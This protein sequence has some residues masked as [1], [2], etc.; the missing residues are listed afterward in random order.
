M[1]QGQARPITRRKLQ[2]LGSRI[3]RTARFD[4]DTFREL[5]EDRSATG[6]AIA[7]LLIVGLSYGLGFSIFS[8]LQTKSLSPSQ[9][10]SGTIANM[11]FT[12]FAAFA[13]MGCRQVTGNL[14]ITQTELTSLAGLV[15]ES[16][17]GELTIALNSMLMNGTRLVGPSIGGLLIAT[18][19]TL[20]NKEPIVLRHTITHI[21]PIGQGGGTQGRVAVNLYRSDDPEAPPLAIL[22]E[23]KTHIGM[24]EQ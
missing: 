24:W 14:R 18:F 10:I 8:G 3:I 2:Q 20:F 21:P 11:I 9:L 6:Q 7:V 5:K 16:I 23:V 4:K 19:Y 12:D 22:R 13:K 17:G 15:I 1:T